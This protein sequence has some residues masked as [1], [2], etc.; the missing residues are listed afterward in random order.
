DRA[1]H[2][3]ELAGDHATGAF[4]NDEA[5]AS[6]REALAVTDRAGAE[7]AAAAVQLHAKLANVLWR[8]ARHAEARSAFHAALPPADTSLAHAGPVDPVLRAHLY[9]RLGR[10]E[11]IGSRFAEAA[12]AFDAAEDLLAFDPGQA[13]DDDP[14]G[15]AGREA[16]A[17]A[18]HW[19]ELMLDG[20]A[21]L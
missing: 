12:A 16:G 15:D 14:S 19:L 11:L 20:R 4:A 9:I 7:L 3:L 13:G 10:L 17:V 21:D 5:I 2:Y 18:D 1:L 8:T 6:F